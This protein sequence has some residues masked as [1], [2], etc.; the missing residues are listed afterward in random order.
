MSNILPPLA[1]INA[2]LYDEF[3]KGNVKGLKDFAETYAKSHFENV[4]LVC[5][6]LGYKDSNNASSFLYLHDP[7]NGLFKKFYDSRFEYPRIA[8]RGLDH[9][10]N[11]HKYWL[12]YAEIK[13]LCNE[14]DRNQKLL[15]V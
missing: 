15:I 7:E 2:F 11:E 13:D 5:I 9:Y 4:N 12:T 6:G 1:E 3:F 10:K 14:H 8:S